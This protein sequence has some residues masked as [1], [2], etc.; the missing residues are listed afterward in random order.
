GALTL[1]LAG[2]AALGGPAVSGVTAAVESANSLSAAGPCS[3]LRPKRMSP[4]RVRTRWF[5]R[6]AAPPAPC[7]PR[8]PPV[9]APLRVQADHSSRPLRARQRRPPPPSS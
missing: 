5:P 4:N 7:P 6:P 3:F 1:G 2:R 9:P 8:E